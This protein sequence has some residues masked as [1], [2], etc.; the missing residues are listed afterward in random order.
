MLNKLLSSDLLTLDRI[1]VAVHVPANIKCYIVCITVYN[2]I[3]LFI[4]V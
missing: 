1:P 4:T 2:I 3:A